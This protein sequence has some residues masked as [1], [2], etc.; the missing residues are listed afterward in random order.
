[1]LKYNVVWAH[2]SSLYMHGCR[3][4]NIRSFFKDCGSILFEHKR[5][6][7]KCQVVQ[8]SS[9]KC[10]CRFPQQQRVNRWQWCLCHLQLYKQEK[11]R[12]F[13][14]ARIKYKIRNK[15]SWQLCCRMK[16]EEKCG[17]KEKS[18]KLIFLL[19]LFSSGFFIQLLTTY[20]KK[21][22]FTKERKNIDI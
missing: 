7:R 3:K 13:F 8:R 10:S 16:H 21:C 18:L 9:T 15:V 17:K 20:N 11:I 4:G 5:E 14:L 19:G 12:F 6:E 1:M 2:R 22:V